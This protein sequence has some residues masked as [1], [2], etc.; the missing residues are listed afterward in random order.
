MTPIEACDVALEQ[1]CGLE[2]V[3][4]LDDNQELVA[5]CKC[6]LTGLL[7]VRLNLPQQR[8]SP[9]QI[10]GHSCTDSPSAGSAPSPS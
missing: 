8:R 10:G 1:V 2:V 6:V 9:E 4:D 7:D 3:A 5:A